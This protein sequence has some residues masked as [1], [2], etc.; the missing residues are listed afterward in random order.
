MLHLSYIKRL[1]QGGFLSSQIAES[2]SIV[3]VNEN[4]LATRGNEKEV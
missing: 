2:A 4:H 3:W 1:T